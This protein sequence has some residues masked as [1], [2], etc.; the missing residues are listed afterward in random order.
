MLD[1]RLPILWNADQPNEI[2]RLRFQ[3]NG[4]VVLRH[5][6]AARSES[7]ETVSCV[8]KAPKKQEESVCCG[9]GSHKCVCVCVRV[10][11]RK[12]ARRRRVSS[13]LNIVRAVYAAERKE[14]K[15]E[16]RKG[17]IS[18]SRSSSSR[19]S[20]GFVASSPLLSFVLAVV[21][22]WWSCGVSQELAISLASE[23]LTVYRMLD[24]WPC[25][26]GNA[27]D[28]TQGAVTRMRICVCLTV[29]SDL[30]LVASG[31]AI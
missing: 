2:S 4:P 8:V 18:S 5:H 10:C 20:T 27:R 26:V 15:R 3:S 7:L 1:L 6:L 24:R 16:L 12:K 22:E 21:C 11:V 31:S 28:A 29:C 19:S 17:A 13:I 14:G 25:S 30:S 23:V 9:R